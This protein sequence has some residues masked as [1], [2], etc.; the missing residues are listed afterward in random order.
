MLRE[1]TGA[2]LIQTLSDPHAAA[3]QPGYVSNAAYNQYLS[4][5]ELMRL[6]AV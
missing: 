6:N 1:G 3:D 4:W 2:I 5:C